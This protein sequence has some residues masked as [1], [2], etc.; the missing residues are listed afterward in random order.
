MADIVSRRRWRKYFIVLSLG[1]S[2][3]ACTASVTYRFAD[4]VIAWEV[5]KYIEWND[6]QQPVF[7][8]AVAGLLQWHKR[9]QLPEYQ[10]WL[11]D[12]QSLLVAPLT[13]VT[14]RPLL[15]QTAIFWRAAMKQ[16]TPV[17]VELLASLTDEQAA[18]FVSSL[19]E[20]YREDVD[21]YAGDTATDRLERTND[22]IKNWLGSLD[23]KQ[24]VK[25]GQAVPLRAES[26]S[27]WLENRRQWIDTLERALAIRRED[28][29]S[30]EIE[31]LLVD[32]ET[33]WSDEYRAATENNLAW[34][35]QL[36]V[37][38]QPTLSVKQQRKLTKKV[39]DLVLSLNKIR[40]L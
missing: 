10:R 40:A 28:G 14:L 9:E 38:L 3:S 22:F 34:G 17:A 31:R 8:N 4:W 15:E 16:V 33:F 37:D 18:A 5:D 24:R 27:L 13:P 23:K 21:K 6:D 26:T 19:R 11:K 30:G 7:D 12:L 1:L 2:L 35:I 20:S 32:S 36:A 29:F 39:N 25:L